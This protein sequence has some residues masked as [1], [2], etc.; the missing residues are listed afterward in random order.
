[1]ELDLQTWC[2]P[3]CIERC[4]A[5]VAFVLPPIYSVPLTGYIV[6]IYRYQVLSYILFCNFKVYNVYNIIYYLFFKY[7]I[8]CKICASRYI[9]SWP[10]AWS[11]Y[12]KTKIWPSWPDLLYKLQVFSKSIIYIIYN[13]AHIF[14]IYYIDCIFCAA[15]HRSS[16]FCLP[17]A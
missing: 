7:H 1:M 9:F 14:F 11:P 3:E 13:M 15:C 2:C 12:T 10:T 17:A 6:P 5:D 8:D 16:Q 4:I